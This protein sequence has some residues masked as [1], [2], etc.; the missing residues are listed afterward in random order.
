M[1]VREAIHSR[2]SVKKVSLSRCRATIEKL[3]M[4]LQARTT[5]T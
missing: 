5:T 4:S 2:H 3:L 1:D